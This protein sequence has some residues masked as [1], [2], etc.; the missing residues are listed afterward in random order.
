MFGW[1]VENRVLTRNPAVGIKR[2]RGR[3]RERRVYEHEELN[4]LGT[5]FATEVPEQ[6]KEAARFVALQ[7]EL[8]C[9]PGE[10]SC[11]LRPDVDVE[12]RALRF[13]FTKHKGQTRTIPLLQAALDILARQLV[14]GAGTATA[15]PFVFT[16]LSRS[17]RVPIPFHYKTAIARLREAGIVDPDFSA[18][19]ARHGFVSSGFE[20]GLSHADIMKMTGH[21]SYAAVEIYNQ[22]GTLHPE[23][24]KRIGAEAATR[25]QALLRTLMQ[26]FGTPDDAIDDFIRVGVARATND[27]PPTQSA[28]G[29]V[30]PLKPR[31]PRP[32]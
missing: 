19:A 8:G 17:G 29:T 10:L 13:R 1:A 6:L 4:V 22:S 25:K 7:R 20:N 23:V 26:E 27:L 9:R 3:Q 11:V 30:V 14:Y 12:N 31:R 16:S 28:P 18:H 5:M 24:R 2:P 32:R 15:S 21:H